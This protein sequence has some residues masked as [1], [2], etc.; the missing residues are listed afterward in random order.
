VQYI[1]LLQQ[2][3]TKR[4]LEVEGSSSLVKPAATSGYLKSIKVECEDIDGRVC[5]VLKFLSM[6][7]MEIIIKRTN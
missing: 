2:W 4:T 7:D 6:L 3:K 5:K 1:F